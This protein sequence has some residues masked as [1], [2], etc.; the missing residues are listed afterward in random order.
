MA[1]HQLI[2]LGRMVCGRI[3]LRG[4]IRAVTPTRPDSVQVISPEK[5]YTPF[6]PPPVSVADIG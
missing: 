3:S 6:S 2:I 4:I 1:Y 5:Q